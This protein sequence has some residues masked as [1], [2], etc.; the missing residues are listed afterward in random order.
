MLVECPEDA[1][2]RLAAALLYEASHWPW[3]AA[4][5]EAR[6]WTC[7]RQR[8]VI[9]TALKQRGPY[10]A[11]LRA[12]EHLYYTFDI[13]LDFGAFRDVQRHRMA[14]QTTQLLT[15]AHGYST[16]EPLV[17]YDLGDEFAESMERAA[18]SYE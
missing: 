18:R 1:G 15:T 12:F 16:P 10:D 13:L 7:E 3:E 17:E 14:T 8:E 5:A 2:A 6:S 11:P 4:R 9:E